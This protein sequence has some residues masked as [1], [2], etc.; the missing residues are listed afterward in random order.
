MKRRVPRI[1]LAG[2]AMAGAGAV[3]WIAWSSLTGGAA[4]PPR[5]VLLITIDTLRADRLGCY[6]SDKGLTP[7]LDAFAGDAT[8]FSTAYT[9]VPLTAPSHATILTGRYPIS[10]GLRNNGGE[11]LSTEETL[12]SEILHERGF[13]TAA[14]VS[15]LVL[16][17]QFGL[18]Q[19]FDLYYE[20]GI[21]GTAHGEGLWFDQRPADKTVDRAL[22]WLKAE[23]DH[24]FF[25]WV[26]L[27]DP[28]DPYDPPPPYKKT[29][30]AAPYNGEVA[31]T[32]AQVGRLLGA[33]RAMG[34]YDDSII[35][36]VSDHGES[37]GEHGEIYH[38]IFLYDATTR[39]PLII[40]VPGGRRGRTITDLA[41]TIDIAPTILEALR[42]PAPPGMQGVSLLQAAARGA[43]VEA[44]SLLLET[45]FPTTSY[46][47]ATV[48]ALVVPSWKLID[49]PKPEL[50]S[51][52]SDPTETK[53]LH[54]VR[55][56][57]AAEMQSEYEQLS[58]EL[59]SSA[60]QAPPA[61]IDDETRDRLLSLGY[62]G[63]QQSKTRGAGKADPKDM[64]F[65]TT[66]LRIG[67]ALSREGK[68]ADAEEVF[69]KAL[70]VDPDNRFALVEIGLAL[71]KDARLD[72]AIP[73][74]ERLVTIYADVEEFYRLYGSA[75]M[76][77]RR[78]PDAEAVFRR[79][80]AAL[81]ESAPMHFM[82]GYT[83]FLVGRCPAAVPELQLAARLDTKFGKPHYL[84]AVCGLRSGDEPGAL[85][86]LE[87]Y[88]KRDPDVESLFADPF[89]AELRRKPVFE[90]L[91]RKHL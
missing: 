9:P 84:L 22:G 2:L 48:R 68:Y 41:S 85:S 7:A 20:E 78:L 50:Y 19:G 81:P 52:A 58:A 17:S 35:I 21:K 70:E 26:H 51:M 80:A 90:E 49:L 62:I 59:E 79:A 77:A 39:V 46:G 15:S 69:R 66:P 14:I 8:S 86:A 89:F 54:A 27:F 71:E 65:M 60:R 4:R 40:R 38:A 30:A 63:G 31:F 56:A 25:L 75:F 10:H 55:S 32:D 37:L 23:A 3:G 28:H 73:F 91:L 11:A 13:R 83:R 16:S 36:V 57:Q 43:R 76:R 87:E 33:F 74:F 47:W 53:N 6:G 1:V 29:Y 18:D 42:I 45:I 12:V 24:P 61:S 72:E 88:L 64:V 34:L 44:R 67:A 82:L 5:N